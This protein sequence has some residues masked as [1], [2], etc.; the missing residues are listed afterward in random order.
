MLLAG[1]VAFQYYADA[2]R[3]MRI[4]AMIL[5]VVLA[6][7]LASQT[8]KGRMVI[9]FVR[10][11]QIEVRKVVWPTYKEARQMTGYVFAFV[12]VMALFL[13]I[14]DGSLVW[15]VRVMMGRSE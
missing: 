11:A 5:D 2:P 10:D 14:V 3:L 15:L 1:V 8:D 9:G 4:G 12:V 13:W 6:V 7:V